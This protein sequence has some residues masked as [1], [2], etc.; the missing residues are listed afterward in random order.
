MEYDR[1]GYRY[2]GAAGLFSAGANTAPKNGDY[3]IF[4]IDASSALDASSYAGAGFFERRSSMA[5]IFSGESSYVAAPD[6][7]ASPGMP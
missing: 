2:D 5:T 1:E 4:G 6:W 7:T 3:F